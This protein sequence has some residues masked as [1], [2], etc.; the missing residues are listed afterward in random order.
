VHVLDLA[1]GAVHE[2][3]PQGTGVYLASWSPDGRS[4]VFGSTPAPGGTAST[5]LLRLLGDG[6]IPARPVGSMQNV[7]AL[8]ADWTADSRF[9]SIPRAFTGGRGVEIIDTATLASAGIVASPP[10]GRLQFAPTGSSF[11]YTVDGSPP[12]YAW[13]QVTAAGITPAA[14]EPFPAGTVTPRFSA[15]GRLFYALPPTG[16]LYYRDL[17]GPAA[18]VP[19][20]EPG[21]DADAVPEPSGESVLANTLQGQPLMWAVRRFYVDPTKPPVMVSDPQRVT[22]DLMALN[23]STT[24]PARISADGA[25][26]L[27]GYQRSSDEQSIELVEARTLTRFLLASGLGRDLRHP[28]W[29]ATFWGRHLLYVNEEER[30]STLQTFHA[31]TIEAG[32]LVDTAIGMDGALCLT[33]G[34]QPPRRPG[35][36]DKL[37]YLTPYRTLELVDLRKARAEKVA[38]IKPT[39]DDFAHLECPVW[40]RDGQAFAYLEWLGPGTVMNRI[41]VVSWGDAG[42]GQPRLVHE[43]SGLEPAHLDALIVR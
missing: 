17:P 28:D 14:P 23:E 24:W 1:T 37:V 31:A 12:A 10:N 13:G 42:P 22:R 25:L 15:D 18:P 2:G 30:L 4:F 7:G 40:S 9:V 19:T 16:R 32:Q 41:F 21:G 35:P 33:D 26:Y 5:M 3:N 39:L 20:P 6:F 29:G 11:L 43:S 38:T 34:S 36:S 27:L 8:D